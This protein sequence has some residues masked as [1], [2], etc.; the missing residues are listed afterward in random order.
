M[1]TVILGLRDGNRKKYMPVFFGYLIIGYLC[2]PKFKKELYIV[3]ASPVQ[4]CYTLLKQKLL[5][6]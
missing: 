6:P 4:S 5:W 2:V 3:V 1:V